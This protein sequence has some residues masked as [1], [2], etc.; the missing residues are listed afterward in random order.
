MSYWVCWNL[1][2][3]IISNSGS[4]I[5]YGHLWNKCSCTQQSWV[6]Y[7]RQEAGTHTWHWRYCQHSAQPSPQNQWQRY[8]LGWLCCLWREKWQKVTHQYLIKMMKDFVSNTAISFFCIALHLKS[9]NLTFW[10]ILL[11]ENFC[12]VV[13]DDTTLITIIATVHQWLSEVL[14]LMRQPAETLQSY[15]HLA[16]NLKSTTGCFYTF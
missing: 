3:L 10:E 4:E 16:H 13:G 1:N 14:P 15:C 5:I 9:N 12:K 6:S 8:R 7:L 11:L 2:D